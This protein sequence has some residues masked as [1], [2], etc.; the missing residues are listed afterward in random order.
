M[1]R[2]LKLRIGRERGI[3]TGFP[4]Q[5]LLE[6][7]FEGFLTFRHLWTHEN[8]YTQKSKDMQLEKC[9]TSSIAQSV[10]LEY[11]VHEGK[12]KEIKSKT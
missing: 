7:G 1:V 5:F 12:Y 4:G 3:R 2:G 10:W 6:L 11:R 9:K 8:G